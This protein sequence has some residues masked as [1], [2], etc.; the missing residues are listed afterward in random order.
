MICRKCGRVLKESVK[1][2]PF[3]EEPI[4]ADGEV[5]T[6]KLVKLRELTEVPSDKEQLLIELKRLREYFLKNRGKYAVMDDLW[7]MQL[8]WQAPSLLHWAAGG[9]LAM[10]VIYLVLYGADLIPH[11]AWAFFFILW[12][13]V[14]CGGYIQSSRAYEARRMRWEKDLCIVKN[15]IR[16]YYNRAEACFL[17]LDYSDPRVIGE[18]IQGLEEGTIHS[19]ADY[20]IH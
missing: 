19:F 1:Y 12:G 4:T 14:A 20:R 18:L 2:C 5:W 6:S 15:D 11:V 13:C 3:C 9:L 16:T 7:S 10:S 8:K 17:P